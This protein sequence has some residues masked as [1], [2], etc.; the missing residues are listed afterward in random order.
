MKDLKCITIELSDIDYKKFPSNNI[1]IVNCDTK[2]SRIFSLVGIDYCDSTNEDIG[3]WR[4]K[5]DSGLKL[6]LI[7]D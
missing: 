3:G 5:D 1:E 2:K 6:L 4:Y 7:N